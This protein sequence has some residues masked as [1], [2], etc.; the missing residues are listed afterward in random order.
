MANPIVK[1]PNAPIELAQAIND[2]QIQI[3]TQKTPPHVIKQRPGK[4]GKRFSYVEHAWVTEQL[5][6][7]FGWA[8]DWEIVEW[9]LFPNDEEP[10][11]CMV[12]GRLTVSTPEG[13]PIT[14]M[15][16]G[17]SD[18]KRD[19]QKNI[20]SAADDLKAASSDG[21]KKAASLL[22]LALD[23]YSADVTRYEEPMADPETL[24][25]IVETYRAMYPD[26]KRRDSEILANLVAAAC[27]GDTALTQDNAERVL[28]R[29]AHTAQVKKSKKEGQS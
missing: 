18:I 24:N 4:G 19:R 20:L 7:A 8:W 22:G 6:L 15:Q 12:L 13:R 14:K 26:S 3:L 29:M 17:S 10:R 1:S 28:E 25:L 5:N 2:A 21:L 16:F 11:E 27:D 23:L 9:R